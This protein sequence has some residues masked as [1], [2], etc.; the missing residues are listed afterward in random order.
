VKAI[1][2]RAAGV[3][4]VHQPGQVG[5][6]VAGARPHGV[7]EGIQDQR[8][9]HRGGGPPAGDPAGARH[10]MALARSRSHILRDPSDRPNLLSRCA[11]I[12]AAISLSRWARRLGVRASRSL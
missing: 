2:V 5:D 8:G 10:V 9:G 4:V 6:P 7:L 1:E 11:A 3:V 12:S